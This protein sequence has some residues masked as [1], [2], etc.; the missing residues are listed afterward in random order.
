MATKITKDYGSFIHT[1][2]AR[3]FD[4]DSEGHELL[5]V[6]V[7][8]GEHETTMRRV[9]WAQKCELAEAHGAELS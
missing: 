1:I 5:R 9:E 3:Y 2:T 4:T 7:N 6:V 8:N